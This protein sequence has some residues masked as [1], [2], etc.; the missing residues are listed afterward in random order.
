MG[1]VERPPQV[2][3]SRRG[4]TNNDE[5]LDALATRLGDQVRAGLG[6]R[7]RWALRAALDAAEAEGIAGVLVLQISPKVK[8]HPEVQFTIGDVE[9]ISRWSM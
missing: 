3:K 9:L 2:G 1:H 8:D 5:E 4:V 7:S 6:T